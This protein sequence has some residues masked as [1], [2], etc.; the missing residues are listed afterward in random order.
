MKIIIL[1]PIILFIACN[2]IDLPEGTPNCVGNII[3]DI[4]DEDVRNPPASVTEYEYGGE[5]Y[6]YV[7]SYCCDMFSALYD[8]D[9]N[10]ICAPDGGFTGG[11]DGT[12]PAFTDSLSGGTVIWEDK[13]Q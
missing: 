5:K 3:K 11:G 9:C 7:P 13:R 10:Y 1:L 8:S 12:C 2:K 4:L 6:Y